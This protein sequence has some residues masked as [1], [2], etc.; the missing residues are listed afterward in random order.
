M[1]YPL[2]LLVFLDDVLVYSGTPARLVENIRLMLS[3]LA[4]HGIKLK[5]KK[6]ELFAP[7]LVWCGHTVSAAGVGIAEEYQQTLLGVPTPSTAAE[8]QQVLAATNWVR[9]MMPEY[10]RTVAP[11]RR[12]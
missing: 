8:L 11:C 10:A 3:V 5:P 12:C 4:Q 1:G 6:C 9:G 2:M 7:Q